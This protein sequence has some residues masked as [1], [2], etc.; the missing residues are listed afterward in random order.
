MHFEGG[1]ASDPE[2]ICDLFA[3]F[4]QRTCTDDVWVPS[5]SGLEHV[6]DELSFGSLK[7]NSVEVESV[8]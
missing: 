2:E 7:L 8:L 5:D 1:L 6:T 4:K 3:E